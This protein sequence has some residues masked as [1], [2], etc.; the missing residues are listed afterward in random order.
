MV[1]RQGFTFIEVMIVVMIVAILAV[2]VVPQLSTAIQD[3]GGA[4]STVITPLIP[5]GDQKLPPPDPP[6]K[7]PG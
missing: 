3:A 4:A 5:S 1:T 2:M 7:P 6:D